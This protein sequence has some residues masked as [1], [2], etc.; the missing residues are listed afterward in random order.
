[1]VG[2]PEE[3]CENQLGEKKIAS[4]I[5]GAES[6]VK[7]FYYCGSSIPSSYSKKAR[8]GE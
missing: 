2:L 5:R 8:S 7:S 1:L 4:E 3:T 6:K